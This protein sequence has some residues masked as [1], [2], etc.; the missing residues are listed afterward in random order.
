MSDASDRSAWL[1]DVHEIEQLLY[2]YTNAVDLRTFELLDACFTPDARIELE[3][4][5][6]L[7]PSEYQALC[8]EQLPAFDAT[9]H[10]VSNPSIVVDGD[11]ARSHAYFVAQHVKNALAP[12]PFLVIG[13]WY[14]DVLRRHDGCWR[15]AHRR[16]TGVWFDGNPAVLGYPLPPGALPRG[17]GHACPDWLLAVAKRR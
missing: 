11:T 9:Q 5:G 8:R 12:A 4:L 1:F 10:V 14:D 17:A 6:V 15:I 7:S 2:R 13:G 16:G 3:G